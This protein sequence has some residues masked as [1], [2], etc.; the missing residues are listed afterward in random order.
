[1]K[2]CTRGELPVSIVKPERVCLRLV[3]FAKHRLVTPDYS[4]I[5]ECRDVPF[6]GTVVEGGEPLC[7]IVTQDRSRDIV[8]EKA[9]QISTEIYSSALP[10]TR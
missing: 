5:K 9:R 7:S 8:V 10:L 4:V 3:L 6:P 2:A 1:V